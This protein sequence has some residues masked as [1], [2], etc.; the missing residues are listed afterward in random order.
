VPLVDIELSINGSDL[1][2]DVRAFLREA[3]LRVGQF[4]RNSPIRVNG[5]APSGFATV[6]RSL[7]AIVEAKLAPGK[8]F[9]EWGSGFG[10]AASLAAMLK[11]RACG[12]EIERGLVDASKRLA[13]DFGLPVEF[14]HG[15]FI[16]PGGGAC[17]DEACANNNAEFI[18]LVTDADNAYSE[19]GLDPDNF[20]V[21]FAYPW[22]REEHVIENLFAHY[23]AEGALL[24]TYNKF[25][26]VRLRQKV[27]ERSGGS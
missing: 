1:P 5:F 26:S 13:D 19:L 9:C 7:R 3:Y 12:V 24:L 23:A 15:S 6:Y 16:P 22:P 11:F 14:V 17:A 25:H 10:V 2:S 27:G 18:G 8:S 20:D 4:V 21:F